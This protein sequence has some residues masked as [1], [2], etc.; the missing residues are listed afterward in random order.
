LISKTH[1]HHTDSNKLILLSF[2]PLFL[3]RE[4]FTVDEAFSGGKERCLHLHLSLPRLTTP[5]TQGVTYLSQIIVLTNGSTLDCETEEA[6]QIRK[7]S[8][9]DKIK[10]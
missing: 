2:N 10:V 3:S 4:G 1:K 7:A 5:Y 8:Q 6:W 9:I